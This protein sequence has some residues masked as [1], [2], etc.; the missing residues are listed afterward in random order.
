[1][2]A[3]DTN[4]LARFYVAESNAEAQKQHAI[5]AKIMA[6]PALFVPRTVLLELEWVL[7]GGY[8]YAREDILAVFQHL[9]GLANVTLE[10][11]EM[12]SDALHA[13]QNG[14]DFADALHLAACKG[15]SFTTFDSKLAKRARK[16]KLLPVVCDANVKSSA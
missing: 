13:Y 9:S 12:V 2:N 6:Q 14:M 11:W 16:L 5:A 10:N 1:M 4:I 15:E 3:L 7:R 8:G